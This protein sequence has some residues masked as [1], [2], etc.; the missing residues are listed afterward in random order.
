MCVAGPQ[1]ST[2]GGQEAE[3]RES[4][5]ENLCCGFCR[6]VWVRQGRYI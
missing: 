5:A 1:G 2:R 3:G 4:V 6:K